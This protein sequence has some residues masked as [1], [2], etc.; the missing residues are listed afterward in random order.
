MAMA[1]IRTGI[2]AFVASYHL[3][4]T[5]MFLPCLSPDLPCL[6]GGSD[7]RRSCI[8]IMATETAEQMAGPRSWGLLDF[9][10]SAEHVGGHEIM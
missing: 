6:P 3:N 4:G 10:L 2:V 7:D 5:D 8:S 9:P 1:S